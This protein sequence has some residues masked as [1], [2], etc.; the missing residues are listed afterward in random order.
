[1]IRK[2]STIEGLVSRDE[3]AQ[4]ETYLFENTT[5]VFFK[6][7]TYSMCSAMVKLANQWLSPR[8]AGASAVRGSALRQQLRQPPEHPH[9]P[10]VRE[11]P[12]GPQHLHLQPQD[13]QGHQRSFKA[14][15]PLD[16]HQ[17]DGD[18][19]PGE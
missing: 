3:L 8:N 9:E 1:L 18:V 16:R 17:S 13:L 11:G 10:G 15:R 14:G 12:L 6:I 5:D 4:E 19:Q 2:F 7:L